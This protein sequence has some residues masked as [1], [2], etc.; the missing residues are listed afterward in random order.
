VVM[1]A[2]LCIGALTPPLA[3]LVFT[4]ARVSDTPV[5]EAYRACRPFLVGLLI[6]LAVISLVPALTLIPVKVF[7]P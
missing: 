1:V 5:H 2:N 3:L 6:W 4:A 7:G